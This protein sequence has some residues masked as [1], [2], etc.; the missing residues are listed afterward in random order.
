MIDE[1]LAAALR[2]AMGPRLQPNRI[3][4]IYSQF[5]GTG[6]RLVAF[7][8]GKVLARR[9]D[10]IERILVLVKGTCRVLN[11]G[12]DGRVVMAGEVEAPQIF[13]LYEILNGMDHHTA[14][15]ETETE[16]ICFSVAPRLYR[17]QYETSMEVLKFSSHFLATFIDRLLAR[18]DRMT[19]NTDR[20][21]LLLYCLDA[22]K[23]E[24]FP[25]VIV[26]RKETMA[27]E[28][29]M[30]LRTLYRKISQLRDEGL[31]GNHKGKIRIDREQYDTMKR[32]TYENI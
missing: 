15:V 25:T 16:C 23:Y 22:C 31:I 28:L 10:E 17:E 6:K 7:E 32:E 20:Q 4:E 13:G 1:K 5:E 19:L 8:K 11:H 3:R 29:N 27:A 24:R 9:E 21:N 18:S 26:V 30:N 12:S 2:T 14:D